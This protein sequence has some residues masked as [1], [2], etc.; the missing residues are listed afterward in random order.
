M[1][2]GVS[3]VPSQP[4]TPGATDRVNTANPA[5]QEAIQTLSLRLPRVVGSQALAPS[6]LLHGAGGAALSGNGHVD[7][8]VRSILQR[9]L[10]QG[11]SQT[12]QPAP[13]AP[14]GAMPS[15]TA[16]AAQTGAPGLPGAMPTPAPAS[17]PAPKMPSPVLR[18]GG[19]SG[20]APDLSR[21]FGQA[22]PV[23][24][25]NPTPTGIPA[26]RNVDQALMSIL[27]FQGR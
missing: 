18:P 3:F 6:A 7:A 11:G 27:G 17:Q 10:P 15:P 21:P 16:P 25:A 8:L 2:I 23:A 1:A 5:V 19:D 12:A 4:P 14:G 13:L 9:M 24:P 26:P 22:P 20:S